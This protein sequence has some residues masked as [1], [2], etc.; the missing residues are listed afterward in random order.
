MSHANEP[1]GVAMET[2]GAARFRSRQ[3]RSIGS[4]APGPQRRPRREGA[5]AGTPSSQGG[6]RSRDAV[7]AGREQELE[8]RPGREGAGATAPSLQGGSRSWSA[9][10]TGREQEPGR[11]PRREGAG[12]GTP[13]PQSQNRAMMS[14][15]KTGDKL[16]GHQLSEGRAGP[17]TLDPSSGPAPPV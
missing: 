12:A 1:R 2:C 7:P 8:R 15:H 11:R 17:W 9:V 13:S 10:L 4:L 5:G 16:V 6:S 3:H 14:R